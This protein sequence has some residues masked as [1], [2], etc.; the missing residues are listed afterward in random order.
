[1][2]HNVTTT[3]YTFFVDWKFGANP[4]PAAPAPIASEIRIQDGGG[5]QSA[6]LHRPQKD[7]FYHQRQAA[8]KACLTKEALANLRRLAA[9]CDKKDAKPVFT[10]AESEQLAQML[11][12]TGATSPADINITAGQPYRL[13]LLEHLAK[14]S[15]DPDSRLP[16]ILRQGVECGIGDSMPASGIWR[17]RRNTSEPEAVD[18]R[19]CEGNWASTES[20]PATATALVN[21][22]L[23]KGYMIEIVGGMAE[24]RQ[25]W[26]ERI[27]CGRLSIVKAP[28]KEP[29]LVGDSTI[30]GANPAS[31]IRDQ[32]ELPTVHN[33]A[34]ALAQSGKPASAFLAFSLDVQ[35]AHKTVA[36]REQDI[37]LNLFQLGDRL[38][39]YRVAHFGAKWSGYW[40]G[41]L[42]ALLLRILKKLI[43]CE[44]ISMV[45]VDDYLFL[46]PIQYGWEIAIMI[47]GLAQALW[48][49][50]QTIE[51]KS[52]VF[53]ANGLP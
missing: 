7:V 33:C 26:G 24:A 17:T 51:F 13:G 25:R 21:T 4:W 5:L 46:L 27:A 14:I 23:S 52:H 28:G 45:Y 19:L 2:G 40:W 44:H 31:F 1:M 39:A 20:D 9:G 47:C 10:T 11:A 38:L 48:W 8:W 29:R 18:L 42:A 12:S 16:D 3:G 41:R 50:A 36:L 53:Q 22:E 43:H 6:A 30:S 37:G 32:A 34:G 15:E 49:L 35:G